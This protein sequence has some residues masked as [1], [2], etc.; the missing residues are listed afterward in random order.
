MSTRTTLANNIKRARELRGLSIGTLSALTLHGEF[1]YTL[2]PTELAAV[3]AGTRPVADHELTMLHEL[4]N[5]RSEILLGTADPFITELLW[6][7]SG[8]EIAGALMVYGLNGERLASFLGAEDLTGEA[9]T[10]WSNDPAY[11]DRL[12]ALREVILTLSDSLTARGIK[13]WLTAPQ[14]VLMRQSP[15]EL[16]TTGNLSDVVV[17][18]H[19]L[20]QGVYA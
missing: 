4:L 16:I 8:A 18:A 14:R 11:A 6:A 13:Q 19:V 2:T 3:E 10:S 12:A 5:V 20:D 17:A 15:M 7:Q 9:W 1:L